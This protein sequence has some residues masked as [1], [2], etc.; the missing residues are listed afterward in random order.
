MAW[1]FGKQVSLTYSCFPELD[2]SK[3]PLVFVNG[4]LLQ[5]GKI[6]SDLIVK[7]LETL[8]AERLD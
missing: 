1:Y 4:E 6:T 5:E 3:I 7:Q 8:G 2:M